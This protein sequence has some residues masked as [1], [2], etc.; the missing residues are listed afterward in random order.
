MQ[1]E[2]FSDFNYSFYKDN[3]MMLMLNER[4]L[5]G[6]ANVMRE[7]GGVFES[8]APAMDKFASTFASR[9][10]ASYTPNRSEHGFNVLNHGDFHIRNLLF[11]QQDGKIDDVKFVSFQEID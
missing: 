11:K 3:D 9:A 5:H 4:S 8:F 10:L 1:K 6:F 2:D 7:W